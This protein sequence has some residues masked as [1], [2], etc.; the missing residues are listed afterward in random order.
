MNVI[1]CP[2]CKGMFPESASG[3]PQQHRCSPQPPAKPMT[4]DMM[5]RLIKI[6]AE[7]RKN[8]NYIPLQLTDIG[9]LQYMVLNNQVELMKKLEEIERKIK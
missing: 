1:Q 5:E 8:L 6:Q 3:L 2:R 7:A 4:S 9:Q